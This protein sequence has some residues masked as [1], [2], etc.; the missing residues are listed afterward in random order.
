MTVAPHSLTGAPWLTAD[1]VQAVFAALGRDGDEVRVVGG[2][3]RNALLGID[4]VDVDF[5]TTATPDLIAARAEAAG[6]K[7]V[8]TGVEHGTLT[9]VVD[10]RG[11]EV[12]TLR[13]DIE[14]DGRRAVV[15][16]GRDWLADACRRDLTVNALYV[17]A[18]GAVLDPLGGYGDLIAGRIRF[19]GAAGE[20][21]AEDRLRILRFFRFHAQYGKGDLD[22]IGLSASIRARDGIRFLS[23]ERI[24]REMRQ[25]VVA[26]GALPVV[27]AMQD[28]GI[29]PIVLGGVGYLAPFRRLQEVEA[30]TAAT[31]VVAL[32]LA[33]LGCRIDEDVLRLADRLRLANAERNRMR[34]AV[35]AIGGFLAGPDRRQARRMLYRLGE[36]A[37]RDAAALAF[38]WGEGAADDPSWRSLL[39]LPGAWRAPTFPLAGRDVIAQTRLRGPVVGTL[40]KELEAWWI[41]NDFAPDENALRHRLQ[42]MIAAAQ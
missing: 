9:L 24:G 18:T 21:I 3:V 15:R 28:A 4:V 40:I 1:P 37:Y 2:A 23:A 5:A 42:Q 7:T 6:F 16:F 19:I 34:A 38:A 17:D 12:T 41:E 36:R 20:R 35:D 13:E 39:A 26:G 30:A 31:A 32:R 29:L 14:T 25:L 33:A 27:A 22:R 11:F 10:G 8:P